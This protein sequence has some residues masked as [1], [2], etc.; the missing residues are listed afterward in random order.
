MLEEMTGLKPEKGGAV[1]RWF[2]DEYFDLFLWTDDQGH[3]GFDLCFDKTGD[4]RVVAWRREGGFS[5]ASVDQGEDNPSK[6]NS[7]IF[8]KFDGTIDIGELTVRFEQAAGSLEPT[9][10]DFVRAKLGECP[11]A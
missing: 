2:R 6:N 7:P 1:R 11:R 5:R 10:Y 9:L 8:T 3:S 4:Q